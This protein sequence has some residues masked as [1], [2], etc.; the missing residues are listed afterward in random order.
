MMPDA[1]HFLRPHWFWALLPLPGL[2]W[3][4]YRRHLA[5]VA[6]SK[7]CDPHLLPHLLA[8][9]ERRQSF[10]PLMLIALAWIIAVTALAGPVWRQLPQPVYQTDLARVIVL[11]LSRSMDAA[12][13]QPSRLIRAKHKLRDILA[14]VHEGHTA[15][16][17]FSDEAF[18]VSPLTQDARTIQ[19]MV[20]ALAT[21][22]MPR[23]GSRPDLALR[24]ADVLF[25][26]GNAPDGEIIL[27]TDGAEGSRVMEAVRD[28]RAEGRRVSVLAV[29]TAE[30]APIPAAVG[31][32]L[33]NRHGAIVIPRL[34]AARLSELAAAGGGRFTLL[35]ADDSDLDLLLEQPVDSRWQGGGQ[36]AQDVTTDLWREEG[37]WLLLLVLP[38]AALV[39][40][41][42]VLACVLVAVVVGAAPRPATALEWRDLWL[43]PDQQ[44]ARLL[45][46][47]K[48]AEAA[49]RF[50]NPA[51]QGH[52]HYRAGQ[53]DK[54]AELFGKIDSADG[55]YNRGN[56]LAQQGLLTDAL[57][58]YERALQQ[59]DAHEDARFNHDLIKKLLE[60][61]QQQS[62]QQ[63]QQ[64]E[65]EG[66]QQRSAGDQQGQ[67]QDQQQ[68]Q[69]SG[70][71]GEQDAADGQQSAANSDQVDEQPSSDTAQAQTV[72][73]QG[74]P[75][76]S[77]PEQNEASAEG[78]Q[79]GGQHMATADQQQAT[80][81]QQAVEQWLQRIP[82]DPGGL[83]KRKFQR[84]YQRQRIDSAGD[85]RGVDEAW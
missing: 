12:D 20:P 80:E 31:G 77:T 24:K 26:Q 71:D 13:I 32:F 6:W 55:H 25:R 34:D 81:D 23:Q 42:G 46:E 53:Y 17:V 4:L 37:P 28:I 76:S 51:W 2:L 41:R 56:A 7:V 10:L 40:R 3:L 69:A 29:G 19:A 64:Q 82:D 44:G 70:Q 39:F 79:E 52:A 59:D 9:V 49:E 14:R 84:Q 48:P 75:E 16:V 38:L 78:E 22:I 85:G 65:G 58:A 11:D 18:V 15:L 72:D 60:Q 36:A 67:S 68:Q 35:S 5:G 74:E 45:Q 62:Q 63:G 33:K 21:D 57:A 54:A 50:Q 83:L 61:Q 73:E 30:G 66:Q 1:F 27:I 43:R 8:G 47:D